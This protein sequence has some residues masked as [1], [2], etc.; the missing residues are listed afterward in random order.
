MKR[1]IVVDKIPA[2]N[3]GAAKPSNLTGMANGSI[4]L[5][6]LGA[7]AWLAVAPTK[8]FAIVAGRGA[9]SAPIIVPEVDF[10]SLKI[11]KAPYAAGTPLKKEITLVT[12]ADA[13]GVTI[14]GNV[15]FDYTV[16]VSMAGVTL[17][18]RS[19]YTFSGRFNKTVLPKDVA[20]KIVAHYTQQFAEAGIGITVTNVSEKI[21]FTAN[22]TDVIFNL[23]VADSISSLAVTT[24]DAVASSGTPAQIRNLARKCAADSGFEYTDEEEIY[25]GYPINVSDDNTYDLFTLSYANAKHPSARTHED[26]V[27]QVI[28]IAVPVGGTSTEALETVLT[29]A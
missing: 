17:N 1:L 19:N 21:T 29:L 8:D 16:I 25:K 11:V 15:Y 26:T 2:L 3:G 18:E 12:P 20:A 22:S 4:G 5:Y 14:N 7:D 6:E 28:H 24:T 10:K 13:A 9:T 27:N 23:T